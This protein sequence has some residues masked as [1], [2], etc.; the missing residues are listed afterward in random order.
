MSLLSS[1]HYP[2]LDTINYSTLQQSLFFGDSP[3]YSVQQH[4]VGNQTDLAVVAK[5]RHLVKDLTT[6]FE[7]AIAASRVAEENPADTEKILR[8]L[9]D[10]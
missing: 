10:E 2:K 5:I 7:K 8:I 6:C 3:M 9:T 1:K 4:Y